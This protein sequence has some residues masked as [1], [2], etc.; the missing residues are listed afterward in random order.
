MNELTIAAKFLFTVGAAVLVLSAIR[1]LGHAPDLSNYLSAT[2]NSLEQ[3][4]GQNS[5]LV[6]TVWVENQGAGGVSV[7]VLN[8]DTS[9]TNIAV[10]LLIQ[11][12][13]EKADKVAAIVQTLEHLRYHQETGL[14]FSRYTT[15]DRESKVTDWSV[16]SID[17]LH[18]AL[19]LWT[20]KEQYRQTDLG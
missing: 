13:L 5:L 16:S 1:P 19:A 12:E 11:A 14:Y 3:M 4:R 18:L 20:I 2:L 6:D 9:P 10:D 7:V 15:S 17:N 8:P